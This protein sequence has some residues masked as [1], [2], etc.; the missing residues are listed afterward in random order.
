MPFQP[1]ARLR[2]ELHLPPGTPTEPGFWLTGTHLDW[3]DRVD[4]W[5]FHQQDGRWVLEQTVPLG[6]LLEVKVRR[7]DAAS[8][9]GDRFGGRAPGHRLVVRQDATMPL[10]VAGW[11]DRPG[12]ERPSTRSGQIETLTLTHPQLGRQEVLVWL[13]PGHGQTGRR[14]PVLYLHDGQNVFD[15]ATAWAGVEWGADEAA[16]QLAEAG[17]PCILAAVPVDER[18]SQLYTPF[19]SRI[20][21]HAP[22]GDAYLDFLTTTLKPALDRQFQ[23]EP[24]AAHTAV[25]GSS[26]GGLISLYAG[27]R[28]PDLYG[29]VGA[30]SPAVWPGD[31][32]LLDWLKGQATGPQHV[33]LD[34]GDQ[35]DRTLEAAALLVRQTRALA[36]QLEAQGAAVELMIGTGHWHDEAAWAHRFPGFLRGWLERLARR[37]GI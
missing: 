34:M 25:A 9:E 37:P 20:N 27:Y 26:L 14:Y 31:F 36:D 16:G 19:P 17:L 33:Y 29:T 15:A 18:R 5:Q 1:L 7:G 28:R 24:G 8:E 4:G 10:P 12:P 11:Q 23:T 35:E 2:F 22:L 3:Q 6:Q 30:F 32:A 21:G 13:P